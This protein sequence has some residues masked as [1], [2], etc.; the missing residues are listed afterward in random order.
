MELL[1][2][3]RDFI[4]ANR[5]LQKGDRV[6]LA[7]SGGRDSM[8]MLWLF[9]AVGWAIEVAHCNF[10]LRGEA[11]DGDE[12]LVRGYCAS[13][14]VPLH[15]KHFDTEGYAAMHKMSIQMAARELRYRWFAE[16]AAELNC[17]KIAVAQHK[18]DHVETVLFNLSRGTG[19]QGLRGILPERDNIIRPLLFLDSREITAAV[20]QLEV[21]YRDDASNFSTKYSRNKIRL[22]IIPQFEQLNPDFIQVMADNI[23]RFQESYG[24]LRD[25]VTARRGELLVERGPQEWTVDKKAL[26]DMD[27]G[28]LFLLFEPFGFS[29]GV[30]EDLRTAWDKEPGRVFEA[31]SYVLLLDREMLILRAKGEAAERAVVH[32]G[33][34]EVSWGRQL[35]GLSVSEDVRLLRDSQQAQLDAEKLVFP[36]EVRTWQEGD[37]FQPLGMKGKKKISDFFVGRK[38]NVFEKQHIPIWVNGNGDI[39]WV[40]GYQID[41]R[42]KITENTQKVLTLVCLNK[43]DESGLHF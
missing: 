8:L 18:N 21:P 38:I 34:A 16:L 12:E 30:L 14:G 7:V 13:L 9:Q 28:L 31:P 23:A 1:E 11:S 10:G 33:Q 3:F 36:L 4:V 6:L 20:A 2:R 25:F 29:K 27:I 35:F 39:L 42:Y 32:A 40:G 37:Y 22:D 17:A 15:V 26:Q 5:L 41:D 43:K 19:L 24:V